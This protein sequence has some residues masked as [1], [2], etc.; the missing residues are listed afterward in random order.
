MSSSDVIGSL[1]LERKPHKFIQPLKKINEGTD[2]SFFL[3]SQAHTTLTQ[4]L[5][6]L[7]GSA[8]PIPDTT[9]PEKFQG[10]DSDIDKE[11][12]SLT[13]QNLIKL[14]ETLDNLIDQTPPEVGPRRFGNVAFRSWYEKVT[15]QCPD[16]LKAYLPEDVLY[17]PSSDVVSSSDELGAYLLGSFG[18]SQRLDY[19]TGHELSF[20]AFVGGIWMLGGFSFQDEV[21][22]ARGIVVGVLNR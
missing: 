1:R 8:F 16:L 22:E 10:F 20:L 3:V 2:L 11:K 17:F 14:L 5:L 18:S 19:G 4:F 21:S 12:L 9:L 6:Y 15:A 13:S 7:N